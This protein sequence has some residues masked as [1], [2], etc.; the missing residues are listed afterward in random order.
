MRLA[1]RSYGFEVGAPI[2]ETF[3]LLSD[4]R[5]LNALTPRWFDLQIL[6]DRPGEM[7]VGKEF[8]Y[9]LRWRG[10]PFRWH[11]RVTAWEPPSYFAYEQSRGPFRSFLHEHSFFDGLGSTWVT[12]R[13]IYRPPGGGLVDGLIV[14]A[15]LDRIF[16]FRKNRIEQLVRSVVRESVGLATLAD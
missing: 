8:A 14:G 11:S 4:A 5:A 6:S 12:D 2:V 1:E 3:G 16:T 13:V 15:E 9:R 10:L 7:Y